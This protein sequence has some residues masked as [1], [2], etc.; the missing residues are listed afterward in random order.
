MPDISDAEY[1]SYVEY[2]GLGTPTEIRRKR[3]DLENDNRDQREEIRTIKTQ[4]PEEGQVLLSKED[5][6]NFTAYKELGEP[7]TVKTRLDEGDAART[8]MSNASLRTEVT[9]FAGQAGLANEAIDVLV[10]L[11]ALKGAKYEL[12]TKTSKNDAGAETKV[13]TPYV[14]LAGEGEKA[15]SFEDAQEKV[16]ALKGLRVADE[17]KTVEEDGTPT[18]YL[19]QGSVGK[20]KSTSTGK[21]AVYEKIRTDAAAEAKVVETKKEGAARSVEERMGMVPTV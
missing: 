14:T 13:I 16:P 10:S 21:A 17:E 3:S 18:S 7:A 9:A 1:R 6:V 12:R 20:K 15:M 2:Q 5:G 8:E 11:P 19:Q 4:V